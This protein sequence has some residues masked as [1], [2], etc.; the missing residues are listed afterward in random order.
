M[1]SPRIFE[2]MELIM[3]IFRYNVESKLNQIVG[4]KANTREEA[5]D[6]IKGILENGS[7]P[8]TEATLNDIKKGLR[9]KGRITDV[10]TNTIAARENL[11][12]YDEVTYELTND[13]WAK[14]N[15]DKNED[16]S[17]DEEIYIETKPKPKKY[18]VQVTFRYPRKTEITGTCDKKLYLET[19]GL[20]YGE[21]RDLTKEEYDRFMQFLKKYYNI[22]ACAFAESLLK[23]GPADHNNFRRAWIAEAKP[24]PL[25]VTTSN[26]ELT[27]EEFMAIIQKA[28][29]TLENIQ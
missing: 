18:D 4:I 5:D 7:H 17:W 19:E 22:T 3:R 27:G 23:K 6:I 20:V 16:G 24:R 13:K 25:V 10:E 9:D 12:T 21:Y 29:S 1:H 2:R 8:N 15:P 11:W 14:K 28:W 26:D